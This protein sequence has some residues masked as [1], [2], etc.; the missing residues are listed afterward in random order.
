M[1]LD[2]REF[3]NSLG[4]F[5]TGVT[6]V[7]AEDDDGDCVGITVNSF[8]S[9]SLD[10]PLVLFSVDRNAMSLPVFQNA[11]LLAINVLGEHQH[12]ISNRF[13]RKAEDKWNGIDHLV[14]ETGCRLLPEAVA[15]FECRPYA[16][17]DGGDHIIFVCEVLKFDVDPR[18]RPLVFYKGKYC[19]LVPEA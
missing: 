18:G 19:N 16:Q 14:G 15:W 7:T 8:N 4:S 1:A 3:R 11:K 10:P 17:Y 13:A 5:V 12:E 9:V 6:V 2:K